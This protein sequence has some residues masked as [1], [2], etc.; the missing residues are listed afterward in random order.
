MSPPTEPVPQFPGRF[1]DASFVAKG[2]TSAV[3]R[4]RTTDDARIVALKVFHTDGDRFDQ[5][6]AAAG[7]LTGLDGVVQVLDTGRLDD[8]RQ[9]LVTDFFPLGTLADQVEGGREFTVDE[10]CHL[11]GQLAGTLDQVHRRGVVHG[12]VKPSN[13]LLD[14]A[15]RPWLTDFGTA[16]TTAGS[17]PDGPTLTF[18]V[19]YSAPEVL[20]GWAVAPASDQYSLGLLLAALLLGEHPFLPYATAGI[21]RLVDRIRN[22]GLPDLTLLNVPEPA[23]RAVMRACATDPGDRFPDCAAFAV[24]LLG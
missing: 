15:G 12:D 21:G 5:E 11:G 8:G 6:V 4:A 14:H 17:G 13:V 23:A 7:R 24:A 22:V 9:F 20:D 1:A 2:G 16:R 10:V 19:L 18:T 3:Y